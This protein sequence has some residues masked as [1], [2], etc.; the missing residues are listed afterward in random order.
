[1]L[2]DKLGQAQYLMTY[3]DIFKGSHSSAGLPI[4]LQGDPAPHI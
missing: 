3:K 4:V 1:M 2:S